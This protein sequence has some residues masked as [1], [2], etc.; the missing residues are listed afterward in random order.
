MFGE[1]RV[2]DFKIVRIF[3]LGPCTFSLLGLGFFNVLHASS[4]PWAIV[5]KIA[6]N[7]HDAFCSKSVISSITALECPISGKLGFESQKSFD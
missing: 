1:G 3:L 5:S 6:S 4:M 2:R 7:V